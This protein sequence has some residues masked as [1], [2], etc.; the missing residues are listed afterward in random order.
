MERQTTLRGNPLTV[1]GP[2]LKAGDKGGASEIY[3]QLAD[4]LNAPNGLRARAAELAA[5]L[6]S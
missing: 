5:A 2:E 4:D 1:I 6:K 3:K